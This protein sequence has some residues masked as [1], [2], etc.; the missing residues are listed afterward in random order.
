MIVDRK[1]SNW[2]LPYTQDGINVPFLIGADA[3]C[4]RLSTS[5]T[6]RMKTPRHMA[7]CIPK[8]N[9]LKNKKLA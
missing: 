8:Y 5:S 7:R 3:L 9:A 1:D 2:F 4:F 6:L